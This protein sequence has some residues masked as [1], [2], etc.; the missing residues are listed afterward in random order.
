MPP[1]CLSPGRPAA[2][3]VVLLA[4]A[5]LLPGASFCA[6]LVGAPFFSF[7]T[8]VLCCCWRRS[9]DAAIGSS[10]VT[11]PLSSAS[12]E[13]VVLARAASASCRVLADVSDVAPGYCSAVWSLLSAS[14][15]SASRSLS[16]GRSSAAGMYSPWSER[17][18]SCA[19]SVIFCALSAT[20][21]G[22]WY[23]FP[24]F[25]LSLKTSAVMLPGGR[26]FIGALGCFIASSCVSAA[27]ALAAGDP[28]GPASSSTLQ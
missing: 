17:T 5:S 3:F 28:P 25:A 23:R 2:G 15:M 11:P 14:L 12:K 20:P 13:R 21:L 10:S 24:F 6:A 19:S 7:S 27:D 16:S 26:Q 22:G 8:A 4:S 1:A 18:T 9:R